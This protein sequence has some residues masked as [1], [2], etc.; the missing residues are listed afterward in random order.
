[1]KK[2]TP[3]TISG[4]SRRKASLELWYAQQHLLTTIRLLE[5]SDQLEA[6]HEVMQRVTR[7]KE[8]LK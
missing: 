1:M 4:E 7:I 2:I 6:L 3:A 8:T 5:G